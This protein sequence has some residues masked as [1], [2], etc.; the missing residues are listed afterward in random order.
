M[1]K[2]PNCQSEFLENLPFCPKCGA[3]NVVSRKH[4]NLTLEVVSILTL[5]LV[6]VPAALAGTC[7]GLMLVGMPGDLTGYGVLLASFGVLA[8]TIW[9]VRVAH[10]R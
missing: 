4:R 9:F 2:C 3:A 7:A 5:I 8:L 1:P 10:R 6:G